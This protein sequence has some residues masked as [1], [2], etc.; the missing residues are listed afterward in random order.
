MSKTFVN[1]I[2]YEAGKLIEKRQL[3][4]QTLMYCL[5]YSGGRK[6]FRKIM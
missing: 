2:F 5:I 4:I 6:A 3:I 1:I